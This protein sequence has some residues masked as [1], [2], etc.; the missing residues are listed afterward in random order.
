M[1]EISTQQN[2]KKTVV[3]FIVGLI[4]GGLLVW[5]FSG[6]SAN[7][8]S[9]TD[10]MADDKETV[11]QDDE[12]IVSTTEE[13]DGSDAGTAGVTSK[14][15]AL[16]V[17]DGKVEVGDTTAGTKVAL[18]SVTFPVAEGWV[19]VRDYADERLG[20]LL[21]VVRFSKEQGLIPGEVY[22][23]RA[24]KAGSNYAIVMYTENGDR[25]FNLA[26]DVQI[27]TIFATFTAK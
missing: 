24:T 23:Q 19:G 26:N 12:E 3:A 5:A 6:P 8:P 17:G 22:L 20:G 11:T 25:T 27:D 18:T 2:D 7:A 9:K 4:I 13:G 1:A 21:G 10:K 14:P 16:P 15:V